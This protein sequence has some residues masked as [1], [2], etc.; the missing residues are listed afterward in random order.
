MQHH[1]LINPDFTEFQLI[2]RPDLVPATTDE[3]TP[4]SPSLEEMSPEQVR[5]FVI[6]GFEPERFVPVKTVTYLY[7]RFARHPLL[8]Y[9]FFAVKRGDRVLGIMVTRTVTALGSKAM[10]IVDYLGHDEGW[11]GLNHALIKLVRESGAEFIDLYSYGIGEGE[12]AASRMVS[13]RGDDQVIVP[14]YF[15]P[16]EKR[17]KD[18]DCGFMV[19]PGTHYRVFKGDSD[20]D[21]PNRPASG[22]T[23]EPHPAAAANDHG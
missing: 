17:N 10:Q 12:L 13:H 21:R 3:P 23:A 20:Q 14:V 8:K 22:A 15:D 9:R 11:I 19:L 7:N 1:Y 2:G 5:D 4:A 6:E 18:L 16:F